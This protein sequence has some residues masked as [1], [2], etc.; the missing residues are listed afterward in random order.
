MPTKVELQSTLTCPYCGHQKTET[1][2]TDY[3][4]WY[5]EC[6]QC[7]TLLTPKQGDCCVYCSYAD[8]PCPP[9]QLDNPDCCNT[10]H[11]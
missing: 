1:M 5:Y 4:Q 7:H 3:C 8:V 2:P 10:K 9:V 6:E 11:D